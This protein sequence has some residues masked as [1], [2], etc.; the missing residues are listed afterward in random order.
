M[1]KDITNYV[2]NCLIC[3]QCKVEQ[4]K[5][6]GHM[7]NRN[8]SR[9]WETVA[10]DVMGPLPKSTHGYEYLL[11]FQDM[12]TRWVEC[13]PIRKSNAQTIIEHL[14]EQV[15]LR[16]GTPKVFFS[17]NE[18][19]FRNKTM[20][21]FL[22]ER[23]VHH[24]YAPPYHPQPNTVERA[25]RTIKTMIREYIEGHHKNWD[26]HIAEFAF[27]MNTA[28]QES[29]QT[30]PVMLNFGR[31][32]NHPKSLLR[33]EEIEANSKEDQL[34]ISEW[35]ARME[36]L[37]ELQNSANDNAWE[38]QVRQA[39]YFNS[40]H[41]NI[42][43]LVGDEIW[44][45]NRVLSSAAEGVSEKLAPPFI[46]P[47][48][49]GRVISPGIYELVDQNG[50]VD[51][52]TAVEHLKKYHNQSTSDSEVTEEVDDNE[53]TSVEIEEKDKEK[54][55]AK[56][57][58]AKSERPKKRGRPRKTRL[59]VNKKAQSAKIVRNPKTPA[60]VETD[61]SKRGRP[62]GSKNKPRDEPVSLSPRRT[63]AQKAAVTVNN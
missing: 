42:E 23:G 26:E 8:F 39:K 31:Q 44:K 41:R 18:T 29:L 34:A 36:K 30:S 2:R 7:G 40:R 50:T 57:S 46:G 52:P 21:K 4:R 53:T 61:K 6:A 1:N 49:I 13:I 37:E 35:K 55:E 16:F 28:T 33:Q 14:K 58:D 12:F 32:P 3:Q 60:S 5:P 24:T 25:N 59:L 48:K 45:K 17:D 22:E 62:K 27:S 63:R 10:G 47:F 38:A 43:Y 19:E 54:E 20:D 51:G 56:T 11:V 15:F 9:P